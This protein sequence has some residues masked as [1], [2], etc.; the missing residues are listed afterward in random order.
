MLTYGTS[1]APH[2]GCRGD[3][4]MSSLRDNK[5]LAGLAGFLFGFFAPLW[6]GIALILSLSSGKRRNR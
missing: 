4:V 3:E 6:A 5:E 1:D 2:A